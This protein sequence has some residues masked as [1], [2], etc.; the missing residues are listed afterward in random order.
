M[1]SIVTQ[2]GKK[3]IRDLYSLPGLT[4][5]SQTSGRLVLSPPGAAVFSPEVVSILPSQIVSL[6]HIP[7]ILENRSQQTLI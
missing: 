3:D 1:H 7:R 2:Q 4:V 6:H 5:L